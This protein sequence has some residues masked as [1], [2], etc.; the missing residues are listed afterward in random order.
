MKI[1]SGVSAAAHWGVSRLTSQSSVLPSSLARTPTSL[2]VWASLSLRANCL[3]IASCR[4]SSLA[5]S[6]IA[7][8]LELQSYN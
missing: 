2:F 5:L 4:F 1:V 7:I 6:T 3:R 8:A